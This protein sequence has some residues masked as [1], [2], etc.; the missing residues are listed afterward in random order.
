MN[1]QNQDQYSSSPEESREYGDLFD[2]AQHLVFTLTGEGQIVSANQAFEKLTGWK[3]VEWIGKRFD[4][5]LHPADVTRFRELIR[6]ANDNEQPSQVEV[7]LRS[8]TGTET[9]V[10]CSAFTIRKSGREAR[11]IM[12]GKDIAQQKQQEED[13]F[14]S[15]AKLRSILESA[16]DAIV[17]IGSNLEVLSWNRAA[18]EIFGHSEQI[19]NQPFE[20]LLAE[21]FRDAY[22]ATVAQLREGGES[23]L[24]GK[25]LEVEGIRV[26]GSEFPLELSLAVWMFRGKPIFAA[27]M[28]DI[29][30][31]KRAEQS[32]HKKSA[33][34]QL[35]QEIAIA[36]NEA[37]SPENAMRYALDRIC[38]YTGWPIGHV[39]LPAENGK[40]LS[41]AIWSIQ[42][43]ERFRNFR[44]VTADGSTLPEK[45]L[46]GLVIR[47]K[48][49]IWI[50]DVTM[51]E[52]FSR[53]DAAFQYGLKTAFAMPILKGTE[54]A[55][56]L[57]FFSGASEEYDEEMIQGMEVVGTQLGFVSER[58]DALIRLREAEARFRQLVESVHAVVWRRDAKRHQFSFVSHQAEKILGY[59]T[60]Q[61]IENPNFWEE[62]IHPEDR[63]WVLNYGQKEVEQKRNHEFEYRMIA[64]D[65]RTIWVRNIV[66]VMLEHDE[67]KEVIGVMIDLTERKKAEDEIRQSRERLR[68]LSAHLQFVRE[69]ERIKIARE[70]HD[71]LGQV[72][73]ALRM[74]LSLLNQNLLESSDT[75]PRQRILQELGTMSHL[76]DDTIRSVRR[77]ITEL[78]PEVLDHLDLSS[79]LEWQIQEFRARTGIKTSFYSTLQNSPLNQ[80]GVTAIFR[81][82]QE[83]LTNVNRHAQATALQVKLI[84][85][86]DSIIL[87]VKDNGRGITEEETRKAGSFGILGMRERVLLLGGNLTMN[88]NPG[89]GTIVRVEIPLSENR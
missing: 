16:N 68:A 2:G 57:E 50:K 39:Y 46:P 84:D 54:V 38:S 6:Q 81:I 63:E 72:L 17:F 30:K 87:E 33:L 65:G 3:R 26:D 34:V 45:S 85:N 8:Q 9:L 28:R 22:H 71:D 51:V 18:Q 80:E 79:A 73:S 56:V 48:K 82:L 15:D 77:I 5:L 69:Q 31:R 21:R 37:V 12:F 29:T 11:V 67:P 35:I 53:A 86:T 36:S 76:V 40:A 88:G 49:P 4:G 70:V 66:R 10:E 19:A 25:T 60:Q 13:L 24:L 62:H 7:R 1:M 74:E 52:N 47:D 44:S 42:D 83:T 41:T 75:A 23:R 59:P 43:E 78:R 55:A 20:M 27:I 61:W 14:E 58:E 89:K 64:S 32:L